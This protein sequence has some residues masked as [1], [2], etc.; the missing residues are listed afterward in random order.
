MAVD[1]NFETIVS[2]V[3]VGL[4]RLATVFQTALNRPCFSED[5]AV[6]R[7]EKM[8]ASAPWLMGQQS[9]AAEVAVRS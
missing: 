7:R 5:A 4:S 9:S 2:L 1:P 6:R 3:A 8:S